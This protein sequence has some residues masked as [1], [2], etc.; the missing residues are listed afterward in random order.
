MADLDYAFLADYAK[1][2]RG[3]LTCVGGSYTHLFV[4][5]LPAT[6]MLYVAGRIRADL[7]EHPNLS[8][9][10]SSPTKQRLTPVWRNQNEYRIINRSDDRPDS[11]FC[12]HPFA[13][14]TS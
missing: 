2:E 12:L 11:E 9:A 1:V 6:H 13:E 10:A 4:Q 8:I 5:K 3:L 7:D 14:E